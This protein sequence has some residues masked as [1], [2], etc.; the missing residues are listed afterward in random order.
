MTSTQWGPNILLWSIHLFCAF[1]SSIDIPVYVSQCCA[2]FCSGYPN[3]TLLA[4]SRC[5]LFVLN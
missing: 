3:I 5:Y 2:G 4:I 1:V